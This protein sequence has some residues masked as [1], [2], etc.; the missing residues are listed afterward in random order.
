MRNTTRPPFGGQPDGVTLKF[1][2]SDSRQNVVARA[3]VHAHARWR[4]C[5]GRLGADEVP[6]K[7]GADGE[8]GSDSAG[9]PAQ[10]RGGVLGK[11]DF[12]SL[13]SFDAIPGTPDRNG[14]PERA[15]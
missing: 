4:S 11:K 6:H 3:L 9:E 2:G 8:I 7:D 5:G 14:G 1:S 10:A 12:V 13:Q 15:R